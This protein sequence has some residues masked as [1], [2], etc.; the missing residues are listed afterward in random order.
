MPLPASPQAQEPVLY[1]VTDQ[2]PTVNRDT[3]PSRD[4]GFT[5]SPQLTIELVHSVGL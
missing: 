1:E 5:L 3:I 2:H 4:M